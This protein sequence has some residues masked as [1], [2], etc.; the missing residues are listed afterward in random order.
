MYSVILKEMMRDDV[1]DGEEF[2]YSTRPS[3]EGLVGPILGL[4]KACDC[5]VDDRRGGLAKDWRNGR[6]IRVV[7]SHHIADM[8]IFAPAED[9]RYDGLYKIVCYWP[10]CGEEGVMAWVIT[11]LE[12]YSLPDLICL[13]Q[14]FLLRRDDEEPA[15]WSQEARSLMKQRVSASP[16]KEIGP[17]NIENNAALPNAKMY[18][19]SSLILKLISLDSENKPKW[20]DLASKTY[21]DKETFLNAMEREFRC[22]ICHELVFKP[23]L[24]ECKHTICEDCIMRCFGIY[25]RQCPVCRF[26]LTPR[27][28]CQQN[29]NLHKCLSKILPSHGKI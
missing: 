8:S 1:D 27:N 2:I 9:M 18:R 15:P 19:L 12:P 26:D 16:D 6:P 5:P 11:S 14:R 29:V 24:T 23:V 21:P 20:D 10:T 17:S 28:S 25:G 4:A 22:P 3:D 13:M 7:R